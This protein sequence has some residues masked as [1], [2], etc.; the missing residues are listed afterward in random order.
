[1]EDIEAKAKETENNFSSS[2]VVKLF[3]FFAD[4][5]AFRWGTLFRHILSICKKQ[6]QIFMLKMYFT[7]LNFIKKENK[8]IAEI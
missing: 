4:F 6:K 1:M 8:E 7:I 5:F 3:F 2:K